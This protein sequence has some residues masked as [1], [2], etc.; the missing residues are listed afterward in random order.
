[1]FSPSEEAIEPIC[2]DV[3]CAVSYS[4]DFALEK[5][6][7][8]SQ[9]FTC[10]N[11]FVQSMYLF[12]DSFLPF[13]NCRDKYFGVNH[14]LGIPCAKDSDCIDSKCKLS[15]SSF[16]LLFSSSTFLFLSIIYFVFFVSLFLS[17]F[18][19]NA[20]DVVRGYC[21]NIIE[22]QEERF[23]HCLVSDLEPFIIDSMKR[24]YKIETSEP[25]ALEK[26]LMKKWS[27][28]DCVSEYELG[29]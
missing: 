25:P 7:L 23:V 11:P 8:E 15:F 16:L 19:R 18:L 9:V 20:G 1:V 17:F 28:R 26:E 14:T 12:T 22:K 21:L 13:I 10:T 24:K 29:M 27:S 2:E 5:Q 3:E 4:S 6:K